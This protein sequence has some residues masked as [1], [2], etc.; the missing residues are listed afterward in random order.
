MYSVPTNIANSGAPLANGGTSSVGHKWHELRA[1]RGRQI[2]MDSLHQRA[3][4]EKPLLS[5][6]RNFR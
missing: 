1:M 2:A 4:T 5:T 3:I 6:T